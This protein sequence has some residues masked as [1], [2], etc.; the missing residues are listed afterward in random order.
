MKLKL[1]TVKDVLAENPQGAY[2]YEIRS[3]DNSFYVGMTL[4]DIKSRFKTHIA[5]YYGEKKY[6]D[7]PNCHEVVSS[8]KDLK[9]KCV[10]RQTH[11]YRT[12]REL[13]YDFDFLNAKVILHT[14]SKEPLDDYGTD[15]GKLTNKFHI[16]RFEDK[17][18]EKQEP[19]A[20]DETVHLAESKIKI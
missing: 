13:G 14:F 19:L 3:E 10:G 17:L 20:N 4:R 15:L 18:I 12:I 8:H 1:T 7:R 9:F 11:G 6:P 5:K 2:V 16:K